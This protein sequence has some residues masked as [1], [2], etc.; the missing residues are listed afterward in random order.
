MRNFWSCDLRIIQGQ[1]LKYFDKF[2]DISFIAADLVIFKGTT[3]GVKYPQIVILIRWYFP[4][5][6]IN[7]LF[8]QYLHFRAICQ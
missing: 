5:E 2:A 8:F 7:K 4:I 3:K 6:D 1:L